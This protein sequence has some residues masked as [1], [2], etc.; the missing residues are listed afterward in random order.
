MTRRNIDVKI[1]E[2]FYTD[3]QKLLPLAHQS[4]P[5]P[6][7][8]GLS[9]E[10][11]GESQDPA[12]KGLTLVP[13]GN[14][15]TLLPL[16]ACCLLIAPDNTLELYHHQI[17]DVSMFHLFLRMLLGRGRGGVPGTNLEAT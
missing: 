12:T 5:P 1:Q 14:P 15:R 13:L 17:R 16:T 9:L 11:S 6:G 4:T 3:G 2:G 8:L 10:P 7:C